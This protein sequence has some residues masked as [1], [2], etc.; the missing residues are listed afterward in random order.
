MIRA[1]QPVRDPTKSTGV[2]GEVVMQ[3]E[4]TRTGVPCTDCA[5]VVGDGRGEPLTH[6][7]TLHPNSGVGRLTLF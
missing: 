3:V 6:P 2:G 7:K 1:R 4:D 5:D